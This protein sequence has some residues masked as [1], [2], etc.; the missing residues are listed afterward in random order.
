M[1]VGRLPEEI[2]DLL[3]PLRE[4]PYRGRQVFAWV[5]ARGATDFEQMSDLPKPLRAWL[6][7]H[8]VIPVL[9]PCEVLDSA[10]GTR[11]LLYQ[12]PGGVIASVLMPSEDRVTLCISSQVG[13][14][15]G[16][17]FCLTGRIGLVRNLTAS[18]IVGQV[19]AAR[20]FVPDGRR[21]SN[22]VFMGMGE[23]LD[24]L[25][26][27]V[28]AVRVI[29]H[30]LGL[31]VAPRRT[32]VSTVGLLPRLREF[33][34]AGT[35]A[36]IAISLCATTDEARRAVVP[37]GKRYGLEELTRTLADL[38]LPHGHRFTIEYLLIEG[39]GDRIED[40]KRLSRMLSRFPAK[41]NLIPFNPWSGSPF[42]RPSEPAIQAF[43]ETLASRHHLVTIRHSRGQD[44]G[45]ACGQLGKEPSGRVSDA[46]PNG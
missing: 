14:R 12:V 30:R 18:E 21:V 28:Q 40:A 36:S 25:R 1:L 7:E 20:R 15:M 6:S 44:I 46:T 45:A 34:E 31:R 5:H 32:T 10:D 11:K 26:E 41:V 13:C 19:L 33:A 23:P 24:N 42:R 37:V 38:Q 4:P 8:A 9:S 22:V 39:V 16:C 17:A 35:G 27:V 3:S 43:Y 2:S 29:T